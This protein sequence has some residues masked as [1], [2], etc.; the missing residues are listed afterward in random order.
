MTKV[1]LLIALLSAAGAM[2]TMRHTVPPP[3][4]HFAS[5]YGAEDSLLA[6]P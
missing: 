1:A 2:A 5:P 3:P 6:R 4:H